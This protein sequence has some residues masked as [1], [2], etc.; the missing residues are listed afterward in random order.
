MQ[1]THSLWTMLGAEIGITD[2]DN[3][4]SDLTLLTKMDKDYEKILWRARN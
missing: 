4:S 3:L 1:L 2:V